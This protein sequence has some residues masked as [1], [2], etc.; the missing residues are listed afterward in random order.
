MTTRLDSNGRTS[1]AVISGDLIHL[2]GQVADNPEN[3]DIVSQTRQ[4]LSA[5]EALLER[6]GSD[7]SNIL[8]ATVYLANRDEFSGMNLAWADWVDSDNPP[9]RVTI[10]AT[11][12]D[13]RWKIEIAVVA[14]KG[15]QVRPYA[16]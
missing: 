10:Q 3:E 14:K 11:L 4:A 13:P 15:K 7:R 9:T 8:H 6:C 16:L 1:Q 12:L 2:A 5:I